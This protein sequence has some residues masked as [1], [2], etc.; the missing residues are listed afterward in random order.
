MTSNGGSLGKNWAGEELQATV[1]H[2]W[3]LY[4]QENL[5][6]Q[7]ALKL[8]YKVKRDSHLAPNPWLRQ[9]VKFAVQLMS[10]SVAMALRVRQ[11]AGS[12]ATE[13]LFSFFD[14][15]FDLLNAS[16][17]GDK[18]TR[19]PVTA[20]DKNE[21]Y[22]TSDEINVKIFLKLFNGVKSKN[23]IFRI[24]WLNETTSSRG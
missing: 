24:F 20:S 13:A 22:G 6:G 10:Q 11:I 15:C 1:R 9:R 5:P 17:F 4:R 14:E 23:L 7:H 19:K 2:V 18:P 8:A 16:R 21:P 12:Q 3:M